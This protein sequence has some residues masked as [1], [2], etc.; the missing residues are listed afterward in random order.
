MFEDATIG[1]EAGFF[2]V[3]LG[4][5][6]TLVVMDLV[7]VINPS[8]RVCTPRMRGDHHNPNPRNQ[9]AAAWRRAMS[10]ADVRA[11]VEEGLSERGQGVEDGAAH[12]GG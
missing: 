8:T 2:D 3:A 4:E 7:V 12:P 9:V 10:R 11:A 1:S 5:A 6:P